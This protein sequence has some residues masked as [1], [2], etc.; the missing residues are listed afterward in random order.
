MSGTATTKK[1]KAFLGIQETLSKT[2]LHT[3][4]NFKAIRTEKGDRASFI[5]LWRADN[6]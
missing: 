4:I 1:K 3:Q 6:Q 5:F 2:C